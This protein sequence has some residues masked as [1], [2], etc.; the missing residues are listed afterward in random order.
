[1]SQGIYHRNNTHDELRAVVLG[2]YYT[3]EYFRFITAASIREPLMRIADEINQDLDT[4]EKILTQHGS[5]VIRPQLPTVDQFVAHHEQTQQ[6]L[7]PPV[8]PRD[9]HSVIGHTMYRV[10]PLDTGNKLV[11][12]CVSNYNSDDLVD[13][14]D[15]NREFYY[16]SM[17]QVRD[18]YNPQLDTWYCRN[19]YAELAGPD[20]P[21]FEEYVRGTRSDHPF[22]RQ[23]LEQFDRDLCYETKELNCLQGPNILLEDDRIVIDSNEY[24]DYAGWVRPAIRRPARPLRRGP[25][26]VTRGVTRRPRPWS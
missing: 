14:S 6:F 1:M 4:F 19:K 15:T 12:D 10:S 3:P 11:D 17:S 24:C 5:R 7:I 25:R 9:C 16:N 18:C 2:N 22:I 26:R 21:R 20:W 23:E 8:N 13:L